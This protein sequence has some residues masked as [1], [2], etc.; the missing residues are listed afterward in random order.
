MTDFKLL[1]IDWYRQNKRDL[2]WRRT[3]SPFKIWLSEV[4]LQQTRVDQGLPYYSKFTS[5]FND[6]HELASAD[7]QVVL[8][9][10]QG[11]G[12]YSRGRNLHQTAKY[13]S[14]ELNGKFPSTS[15]ELMN[16]K[17]IG[18]YTSAAIAS[19]CFDEV[20]PVID[21]NV[22]RVLSRVF[23]ISSPINS[24]EGEKTVKE[25]AEMLIDDTNPAIYNQAIMEFGSLQCTPKN[26][27]CSKCPIAHIC[28][29]RSNHTVSMRPVKLKK[30]KTKDRFFHFALI[31]NEQR[32]VL[33][34]R[35][36]KDIW[37]HLYQFPLKETTY[38]DIPEEIVP[39]V[40]TK[41]ALKISKPIIHI[42][43]HQRL[44][45]QFYHYNLDELS[46]K[47]LKAFHVVDKSDLADYPLPRLIDKYLQEYQLNI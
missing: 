43:S 38:N 5:V 30:T 19:F 42:L 25:Y 47:S 39:C 26:P 23:D 40:L 36:S 10:W 16:L 12:Y 20:V 4:I 9:L 27:N 34:K 32:I 8:N 11:L 18:P 45:A 33:N 22:S 14:K 37:Q 35:T 7:E 6:I 24:I 31:S 2:P 21:G 13:I 41:K 3:K 29:S 28:L 1:I 46:K 17:G 44:H 15:K